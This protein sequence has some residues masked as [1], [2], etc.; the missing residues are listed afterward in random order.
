M[1]RIDMYD[2]LL[3]DP[4]RRPGKWEITSRHYIFTPTFRDVFSGL[5][6]TMERVRI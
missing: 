5:I 6:T 3:P 2:A 4:S 1:T